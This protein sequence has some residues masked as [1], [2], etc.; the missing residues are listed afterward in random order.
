MLLICEKGRHFSDRVFRSKVSHSF[1]LRTITRLAV[2][3]KVSYDK[4]NLMNG[5]FQIFLI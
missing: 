3:R 5:T 2:L 1:K 4:R